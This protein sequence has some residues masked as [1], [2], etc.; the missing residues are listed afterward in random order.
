MASQVCETLAFINGDDGSE[1]W[2]Y[3]KS[4]AEISGNKM[5]DHDSASTGSSQLMSNVEDDAESCNTGHMEGQDYY[6][7]S[8]S[9]EF[10]V[11]W[12]DMDLMPSSPFDDRS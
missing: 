3:W 8:S 11:E 2:K 12:V 6:W 7:V 10:G 5:G 4:T 1:R 9:D